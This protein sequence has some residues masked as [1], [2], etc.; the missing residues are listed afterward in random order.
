VLQADN[1]YS[2]LMSFLLR[3]HLRLYNRY[4]SKTLLLFLLMVPSGCQN[5]VSEQQVVKTDNIEPVVGAE[6]FSFERSDQF[7]I[8]TIRNPW[9]GAGN[10]SQVYYLVKKGEK[11]PEGTDSSSVIFVPVKKIICTST[12]HVAMISELGMDKTISGMS[13]VRYIYNEKLRASAEGGYITEI[14]YDSNL[15]KELIVKTAPDLVMLY[16]IGSESAAVVGKL[17]ELGVRVLFNADYLETF[18]LKKAEWIKVFGALYCKEEKADSIFRSE[19]E[20]YNA[21]KSFIAREVK[22]RPKVLLGLPFRDTWYISPGNSFISK[23]IGDAGGEYIWQKTES[24]ATMPLGLEAVYNKAMDA[25][26]WLNIG[27]ATGKSDISSLDPRLENLPSFKSGNLFNND[28]RLGPTGGNDYWESG[29]TYPHLILK[30]I[31]SILHPELFNDNE[32]FYYRKLN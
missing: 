29:S 23:L 15:N 5:N 31:A 32:L 12:T 24:D 7:T 9:Q 19:S 27:A 16:G 22:T 6:R 28:K 18:P 1:K 4:V 25:D 30:D 13:G 10:V 21:I 3:I 20:S 14:G 17:K 8:L 2:G 11:I 26:F